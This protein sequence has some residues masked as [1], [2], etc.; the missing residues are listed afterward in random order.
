MINVSFHKATAIKTA[1]VS[2]RQLTG[3]NKG[4]RIS[5][6]Q[7]STKTARE[8]AEAAATALLQKLD[9]SDGKYAVLEND[10]DFTFVLASEVEVVELSKPAVVAVAAE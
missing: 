9:L 5:I 2:A 6:A 4:K 10:G 1:T 7:D 3:K 8:N